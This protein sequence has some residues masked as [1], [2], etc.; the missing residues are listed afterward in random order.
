VNLAHSWRW[1]GK[2][3]GQRVIRLALVE[4]GG[5]GWSGS[6]PEDHKTQATNKLLA[7]VGQPCTSLADSW[8]TH[9]P[10]SCLSVNERTVRP[11]ITVI[12]ADHADVCH[13]LTPFASQKMSGLF[14]RDPRAGAFLGGDRVSGQDI[15]D[16]NGLLFFFLLFFWRLLTSLPVIAAQSIANIVK[17]SL[18]PLGLDKMLVDNIGVLSCPLIVHSG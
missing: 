3:S 1:E 18:G 13:F 12:E 17:S 6:W 2:R 10:L 8:I 15:R 4:T 9:R 11:E 5:A 7:H 14:Q 16:Q